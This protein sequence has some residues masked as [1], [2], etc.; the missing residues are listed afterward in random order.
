MKCTFDCTPQ[1]HPDAILITRVYRPSIAAWCPRPPSIQRAARSSLVGGALGCD[2]GAV[3]PPSAALCTALHWHLCPASSHHPSPRGP[4]L[5][6]Q[7]VH[8][9]HGL[10]RPGI[11]RQRGSGAGC[12]F[13]GRRCDGVE[14]G[15]ER[16]CGTFRCCCWTTNC[17]TT[18]GRCRY[19][20][21]CQTT[22]TR[23]RTRTRR[24]RT[25]RVCACRVRKTCA[26]LRL[27]GRGA[28]APSAPP[29]AGRAASPQSAR[30]QDAAGPHGTAQSEMGAGETQHR[31]CTAHAQRAAQHCGS[32][33][34]LLLR[35]AGGGA[36]EGADE[37]LRKSDGRTAGTS[38]TGCEPWRLRLSCGDTNDSGGYS[39]DE[40]CGE[41]RTQHAL[42]LHSGRS[43]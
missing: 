35:A 23:R 7:R 29:P 22:M 10:R 9:F 33:E 42:S 36:E 6:R 18:S 43:G 32:G 25:S 1:R 39:T 4:P 27:V 26:S 20:C 2:R 13:D 21:R 24:R 12:G 41:K 16:S 34:P 30:A 15:N 5:F 38:G 28:R 31:P 11:D 19:H 8:P 3:S 37:E 40:R 14:R 17:R